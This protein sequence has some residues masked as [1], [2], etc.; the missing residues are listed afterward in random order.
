MKVH[1]GVCGW[2]GKRKHQGGACPRCHVEGTKIKE[3]VSKFKLDNSLIPEL[4]AKHDAKNKIVLDRI[5]SEIRQIMGR[6]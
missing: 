6:M 3:G 2:N 1:C 4:K 5:A